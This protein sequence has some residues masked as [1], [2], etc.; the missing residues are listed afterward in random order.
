M[1]VTGRL[2]ADFDRLL[3]QS[4]HLTVGRFRADAGHPRFTDSGPTAHHLIV[5]PRTAVGIQHEG[6]APF[7][8]GPPIVTFYNRGQ[9][10]RRLPIAPDG[11][12]CEW[13]A[14]SS[15]LL[16]GLLGA[17]G[18][19]YDGNTDAPFTFTHGPSPPETYLRQRLFVE[20]LKGPGSPDAFEAEETAM[21]VAAAVVSAALAAL[22]RRQRRRGNSSPAAQ[23]DL[24]EHAK[25]VLLRTYRDDLSLADVARAVG[26]SPFNLC[27][28]FRAETGWRL[29]QFRDQA[30]LR[31][32]LDELDSRRG[33]LTGLAFDLGYSSH[34]HF[35][36][37]FRRA[38]GVTPSE[39]RRRQ[40]LL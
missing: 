26:S 8:A 38:F 19:R 33:D 9:R 14:L 32:A 1:E 23:R 22:G 3:F 20:R 27:R 4:A 15:Q 2:D 29:H 37:A 12:R 11:D 6:G 21:S 18:T 17:C 28:V 10:Y 25:E 35:T 7:V 31:A 39:A 30:R 34:S 36:A 16:D 24:A 5:F 40:G 13:F